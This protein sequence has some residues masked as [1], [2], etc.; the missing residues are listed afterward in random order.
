MTL[1]DADGYRVACPRCQ[2]LT[3][4]T[5]YPTM[6]GVLWVCRCGQ[7]ATAAQIT[8]SEWVLQGYCQPQRDPDWNGE[9]LPT[10]A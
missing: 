1:Y 5:R 4:W 6:C 7:P 9:P 2:A 3:R 10:E 8:A